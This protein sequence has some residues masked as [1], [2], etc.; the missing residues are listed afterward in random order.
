MRLA[1]LDYQRQKANHR[2]AAAI[3][4]PSKY[5][6]RSRPLASMLNESID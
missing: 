4:K 3:N 5:I 6:G 2:Q 1:F